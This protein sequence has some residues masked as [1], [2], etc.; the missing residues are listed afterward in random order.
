MAVF[1]PEQLFV[2]RLTPYDSFALWLHYLKRMGEAATRG[3]EEVV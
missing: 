3:Q 2:R 1:N